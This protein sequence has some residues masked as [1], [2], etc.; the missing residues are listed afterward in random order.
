VPPGQDEL[1][2]LFRDFS[3]PQ[4]HLQDLVL[5]NLF[6]RPRVQ[7][8]GYLEPSV[9]IENPIGAE[10]MAM[11]VEIQQIPKGLDSDDCPGRGIWVGRG[12]QQDGLKRIPGTATQ[13]GEKFSIIKEVTPEELWD[14]EG[15][16]AVWDS[17]TFGLCIRAIGLSECPYPDTHSLKNVSHAPID[18]RSPAYIRR[19]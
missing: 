7:C 16:V 3:L 6:Q 8:R 10:H 9:S 5:K 1:D 13:I 4:E 2:D 19:F 17:L 15:E 11:G 18:C 14:A 12:L